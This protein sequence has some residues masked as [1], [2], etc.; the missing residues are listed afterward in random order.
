MKPWTGKM[1]VKD[2]LDSLDI[3]M[4]AK[5]VRQISLLNLILNSN[6]SSL[7]GFE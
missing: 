7:I 4:R 1:P 6:S 2:F 5:A 3:K